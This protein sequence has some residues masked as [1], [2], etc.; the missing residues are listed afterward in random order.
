MAGKYN[1]PKTP[2]EARSAQNQGVNIVDIL[3]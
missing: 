1:A 3:T 2:A